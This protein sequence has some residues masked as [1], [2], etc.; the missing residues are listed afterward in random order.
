MV[1]ADVI[2]ERGA[3]LQALEV[4]PDHVAIDTTSTAYV[5]D[6]CRTPPPS[7]RN[8][9]EPLS[10][11][12]PMLFQHTIGKSLTIE[13]GTVKAGTTGVSFQPTPEPTIP[14]ATRRPKR[15]ICS[16]CGQCG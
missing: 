7:S 12:S 11:S 6:S 14:D 5:G 8:A 4:L 3:W 16:K 2:Q 9:S 13:L 10:D 1:L 15:P